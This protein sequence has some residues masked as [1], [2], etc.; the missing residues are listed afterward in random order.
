MVVQAGALLADVPGK[1]LVAAGQ[2]EGQ[3]DG[4][5][6]VVCHGSAA[7]GAVIVRAVVRRFAD[8][9]DDR[10]NVLHVKP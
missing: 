6:H 3:P 2:L 1:L 7:V 8:H 5:H 4:L 10:V 9:G